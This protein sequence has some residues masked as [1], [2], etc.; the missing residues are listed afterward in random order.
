MDSSNQEDYSKINS[1]EDFLID[2]KILENQKFGSSQNAKVVIAEGTKS[3]QKFAIKILNLHNASQKKQIFEKL[4]YLSDL[5]HKH[6]LSV[7]EIYLI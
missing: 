3:K 4:Q 6:L 1:H 7:K 2:F 5:T